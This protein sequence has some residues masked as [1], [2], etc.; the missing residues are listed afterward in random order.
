MILLVFLRKK[1]LRDL[2]GPRRGTLEGLQPVMASLE[3]LQA[4]CM[5]QKREER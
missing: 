3:A 2:E 1:G 4:A 5:L